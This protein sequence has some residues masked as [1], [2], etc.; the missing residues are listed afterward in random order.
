MTKIVETCWG[1]TEI[2]EK[3]YWHLVTTDINAIV[4]Y[5]NIKVG[6][7]ILASLSASIRAQPEIENAQ[8]LYSLTH[9]NDEKEELFE[10]VRLNKY[11]ERPSRLKTIYLFDDYAFVERALNEWFSPHSKTV[12]ECRVLVGS[13]IHRA[14]TNWLNCPESQWEVCADNYWAGEMSKTPFPEV[15]VDGTVYF[16]NYADFPSSW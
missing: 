3:T 14:D 1:P 2:Y 7:G 15:L 16:P 6:K 10:A 9:R 12:H 4:F 13:V 11:P 5:N 8:T